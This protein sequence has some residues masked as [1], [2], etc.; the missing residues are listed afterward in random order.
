M[1]HRQ[2]NVYTALSTSV[3][4]GMSSFCCCISFSRILSRIREDY[5]I[6]HIQE[7]PAKKAVMAAKEYNDSI[8][9]KE[10]QQ[11]NDDVPESTEVDSAAN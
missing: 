11:Q 7:K 10:I 3:L 2:V 4:S 9:E 1:G 8:L 6:T 5:S